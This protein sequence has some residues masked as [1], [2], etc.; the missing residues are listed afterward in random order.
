MVQQ[1]GIA[2]DDLDLDNDDTDGAGGGG[3]GESSVIR[4]LRR[5]NRQLKGQLK[6]VLPQ[7]KEITFRKAGVDPDTRDGKMLM[8]AYA[9]GELDA[10]KIREFAKTEFDWD[11]STDTDGETD[12]PTAPTLTDEQRARVE[13]NRKVGDLQAASHSGDSR[14]RIDQ[15]TFNQMLRDGQ[16]EEAMAL[17]N[18]GLVDFNIGTSAQVLEANRAEPVLGR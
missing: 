18:Q 5:E 16:T 3:E 17:R 4:Q 13:Q 12:T 7:V 1:T 8:R 10:E 15:K 2:D 9:D 14:K 6:A 11:L